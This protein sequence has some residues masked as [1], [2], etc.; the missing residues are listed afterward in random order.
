MNGASPNAAAASHL[1]FSHRAEQEREA[2]IAA[3]N[4][5]LTS[6]GIH[7]T[8]DKLGKQ[9]KSTREISLLNIPLHLIAHLFLHLHTFILILALSR[10]IGRPWPLLTLVESFIVTIHNQLRF[11][12]SLSSP[13]MGSIPPG[14]VASHSLAHPHVSQGSQ[15]GQEPGFPSKG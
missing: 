3:N 6:L 12:S 14:R 4:N 5:I 7:E 11:S 13:P 2:R 1:S 9:E 10:G 8:R 15:P